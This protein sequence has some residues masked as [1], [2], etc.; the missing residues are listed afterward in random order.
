MT[1]PHAAPADA[2]ELPTDFASQ[3]DAL[4]AARA[5]L[6][7]AERLAD[8]LAL[9]LLTEHR[10]HILAV[11][12]DTPLHSGD[13]GTFGTGIG[14]IELTLGNGITVQ[15]GSDVRISES[16]CDYME[17]IEG[18][19]EP[20][21]PDERLVGFLLGIDEKHVERYLQQLQNCIEARMFDRG[22]S[23]SP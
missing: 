23:L 16:L 13:D 12:W 17:H 20:D 22:L 7:E 19:I 21:V 15:L 14:D 1:D 11:R 5:A 18:H 8:F 3:H 9:G 4:I 10:G 2:E 6:R